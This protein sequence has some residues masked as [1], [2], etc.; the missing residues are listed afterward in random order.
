MLLLL[1]WLPRL[2]VAD[3][4]MLDHGSDTPPPWPPR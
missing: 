3:V 2:I 1:C 4:S